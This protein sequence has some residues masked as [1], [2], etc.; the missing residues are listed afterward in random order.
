M[1]AVNVYQHRETVERVH[2]MKTVVAPPKCKIK[3]SKS[4]SQWIDLTYHTPT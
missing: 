2:K 4:N 1:Y 3:V